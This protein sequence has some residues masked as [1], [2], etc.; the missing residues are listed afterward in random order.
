MTTITRLFTIATLFLVP[1]VWAET[2][3]SN[4]NANVYFTEPVSG[5]TW[6]GAGFTT[7]PTDYTLDAATLLMQQDASGSIALNLYSDISGRPGNLLGTLT[8]P[9][10]FSSTLTPTEFAGANLALA[11]NSTFW[12]VLQST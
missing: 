6:I 9:S 5:D 4:L 3:S 11:A 7:R 12:L 2:L 1:A 8:N 10:G